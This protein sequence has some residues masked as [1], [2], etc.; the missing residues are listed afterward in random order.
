MAKQVR[1]NTGL[2][3]VTLE[4]E[5]GQV[6][7]FDSSGIVSAEIVHVSTDYV[8][9]RLELITKDMT[10]HNFLVRSTDSEQAQP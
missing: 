6:Y 4:T 5:E 8:L 10:I 1:I 2:K 9:T 3:R 7:E